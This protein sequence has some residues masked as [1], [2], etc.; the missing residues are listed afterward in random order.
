M[1]IF[2]SSGLDIYIPMEVQSHHHSVQRSSYNIFKKKWIPFSE[3]IVSLY[4]IKSTT[5]VKFIIEI[6]RVLNHRMLLV[7]CKNNI[8][9]K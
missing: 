3:G 2:E 6:K 4:G 1:T 9:Y 7:L 8:V 5:H